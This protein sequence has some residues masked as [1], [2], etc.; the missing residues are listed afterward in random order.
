[1]SA[2]NQEVDLSIV[3]PVFNEED[4]LEPVIG[5]LIE[6]VSAF[7]RSFEVILSENGSTD[8]TRAIVARLATAYPQVRVLHSAVP[9]YGKALQK[10]LVAAH[11]KWVAN[12]AVDFIDLDFL[13]DGMHQIQDQ[14]II[15]GSK[16]L[17]PQLDQRP[18]IRRL[19][20]LIFSKIVK[21]L[22][23]IPFSDTHGI[24][25]FRGQALAPIF[26]AVQTG[27]ALF[28]N[29]MLLRALHAN[30]RIREV[31]VPCIETRPSRSKNF[32]LAF[33]SLIGLYQMSAQLAAE[34]RRS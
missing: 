9:D 17:V 20:G 18:L 27:G 30:L 28:D 10:G 32:R 21:V 3:F 22:F 15:M 16:Y 1:M 25:L 12:F 4:I 2:D 19:A 23:H 8:G 33:R 29:E 34:A 5:K 7:S 31:P 11:G 26:S 13:K 14:D 24:K 6:D